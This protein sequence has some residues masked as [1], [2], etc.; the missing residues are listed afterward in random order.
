MQE[1]IIKR[2][3]PIDCASEHLQ[4]KRASNFL[5]NTNYNSLGGHRE[6]RIVESSVELNFLACF[7][8]ALPWFAILRGSRVETFIRYNF[9]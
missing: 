5:Q 9:K 7:L 1:A 3:I 6:S 8:D 2:I 4:E